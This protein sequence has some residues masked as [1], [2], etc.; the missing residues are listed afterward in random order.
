M[1]LTVAAGMKLESIFQTR[2]REEGGLSSVVSK[3]I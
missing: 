2:S 1:V 3:L